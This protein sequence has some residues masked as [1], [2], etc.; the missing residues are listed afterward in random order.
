MTVDVN[1]HNNYHRALT[2]GTRL[3]YTL[4]GRQKMTQ[5]VSDLKIL[6]S[7]ETLVTYEHIHFIIHYQVRNAEALIHLHFTYTYTL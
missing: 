4:T 5:L 6:F 3:L 7:L 1:L 2:E